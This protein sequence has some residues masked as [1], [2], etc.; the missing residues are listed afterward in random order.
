M[1]AKVVLTSILSGLIALTSLQSAAA[2]GDSGA[3]AIDQ[4]GSSSAYFAADTAYSLRSTHQPGT[5]ALQEKALM[6][7]NQQLSQGSLSPAQASELKTKLNNVNATE[8]WYKSFNTPIPASV[9]VTNKELIAHIDSDLKQKPQ[10]SIATANALHEDVD[11]LISRKLASNSI[12]SS[13]AE[14]YY[15]RLA[16]IE[17]TMESA[18]AA[19]GLSNEQSRVVKNGLTQIKTELTGSHS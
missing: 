16:E 11:Q 14:K 6:K 4:T 12:S 18:K 2:Q 3:T 7:I 8:S 19:G 13:Q 10:T 5:A 17:S 15:M 1:I 9:L